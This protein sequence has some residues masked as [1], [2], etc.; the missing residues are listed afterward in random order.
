M[1]SI[2]FSLLF[3]INF[4]KTNS[5][6]AKTT[7]HFSSEVAADNFY[8]CQMS[9]YFAYTEKTPRKFVAVFFNVQH[10]Y[11][12]THHPNWVKAEHTAYKL[13]TRI[14]Q[15][16]W[17]SFTSNRDPCNSPGWV[18]DSTFSVGTLQSFH[19]LDFYNGGTHKNFQKCLL[20]SSK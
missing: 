7:T 18:L 9:I 3:F 4:L 20:D 6:G 10:L 13:V 19:I 5:K 11:M 16:N 17:Y 15:F 14:W 8:L 2:P 1:T 12:C